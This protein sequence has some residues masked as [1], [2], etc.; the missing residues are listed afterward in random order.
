MAI[1]GISGSPIK[2]SNTDRITKALLEKSGKETIFIKASDLKFDPCRGCA[3]LC[4]TTNMCGRKDALHPYIKDIRDAEALILSSPVHRGN[5]TAWM[6]SLLS[7]LWCLAHVESLLED[8]PVVLVSLGLVENRKGKEIYESTFLMEHNPRV[9][10]EIYY[11]SLIPPCLKCG[12]GDYCKRGGLW[13]F[14]VNR[15]EEALKN[16]E[17]T[18]DKFRRWEDDADIVR[19]V[20]KCGKLLSEL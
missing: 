16:F 7:R 10:C 2:N 1:V 14:L 12:A 15:D 18:P 8:K 5:M 4:A 3:H 20:E 17:F 6:F 13:V 11:R 9:L 19:K